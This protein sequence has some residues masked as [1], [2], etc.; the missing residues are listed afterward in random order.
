MAEPL[1]W[2][3]VIAAVIGAL[4]GSFG[5]NF[6]SDW[7]RKRGE[8]DRL[9]KDLIDKY[10]IQLQYVIQSFSNRLYNMKNRGGAQYMMYIKGND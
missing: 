9:R 8:K 3:P 1:D 5:A 4:S 2:V 10:L 6:V 7:L